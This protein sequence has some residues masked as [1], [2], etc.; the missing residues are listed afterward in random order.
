MVDCWLITEAK[1]ETG[2]AVNVLALLPLKRA[3]SPATGFE[4]RKNFTPRKFPEA[5]TAHPCQV[6]RTAPLHLASLMIDPAGYFP[7]RKG[8]SHSNM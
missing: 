4:F 8:L 3:G 5:L 7:C 6:F 1:R 2:R